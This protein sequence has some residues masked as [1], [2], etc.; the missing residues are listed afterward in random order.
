MAALNFAPLLLR[1]VA[2]ETKDNH[3]SD[4][5]L[6]DINEEWP[7]NPLNNIGEEWPP[8]DPMNDIDDVPPVA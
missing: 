3:E 1:A 5:D 6:S 2:T 7:P 4:D 8:P